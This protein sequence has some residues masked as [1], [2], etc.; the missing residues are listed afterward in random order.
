MVLLPIS[1]MA[2]PSRLPFFVGW[3]RTE[4]RL[5]EL[6]GDWDELAKLKAE[7]SSLLLVEGNIM[8]PSPYRDFTLS[9]EQRRARYGLTDG[10]VDEKTEEERELDDW[11]RES[12]HIRRK[13]EWLFRFG[14]EMALRSEQGWFPF[15]YTLTVD[16]RSYDARALIEDD[17]ERKALDRRISEIVRKELGQARPDRGGPKL[18]TYFRHGAIVEHGKTREHHHVHALIWLKAIPSAW[19]L[20]PG[21]GWDESRRNQCE[22]LASLWPWGR[23]DFQYFRHIG[24]PYAEH[25]FQLPLKPNGAPFRPKPPE[26]AGHYMAEYFSKGDREWNHRVKATRHLGLE[27][28]KTFLEQLSLADLLSLLESM[29]TLKEEGLKSSSSPPPH[30]VKRLSAPLLISRARKTPTGRKMLKRLAWDRTPSKPYVLM[31]ESVRAGTEPWSMGS[32]AL[33]DWLV[34][35]CPRE[36]LAASRT[37][38]E[39]VWRAMRELWPTLPALPRE[40]LSGV[41]TRGDRSIR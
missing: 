28:I 27:R 15:F 11:L 32:E 24:D 19:L 17:I 3:Y 13:L 22:P 1:C 39:R 23:C 37:R 38:R 26:A 9:L 25:G 34:A 41:S 36:G 12:G 35:V 31:R 7:I 40:A 10:F 16:E 14:E 6:A 21:D 8:E 29:A 30:L 2:S 20:D 4:C 18:A 33:S 5:A